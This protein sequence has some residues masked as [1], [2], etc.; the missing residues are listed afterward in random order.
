MAVAH[1]RALGGAM[2]RVPND[3]TA[4][5]HRDRPLLVNVAAL[6]EA[7]EQRDEHEAWVTHL[8][9]ELVGARGAYSGFL[10]YDGEARI[11]EAYPEATLNRLADVKKR[12][13]PDNVFHMNHNFAPAGPRV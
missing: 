3:A 6:Y 5:A 1:L 11:H 7:P 10:G 2:A 9:A 13:D 12:Y 4:F 8:S